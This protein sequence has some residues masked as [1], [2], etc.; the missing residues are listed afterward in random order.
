MSFQKITI[1]VAIVLL[2]VA[3]IFVAVSL[4]RTKYDVQYPP[5]Q[6]QCP[7]YWIYESQN[8]GCKNVKGL[9][10]TTSKSCP[11]EMKFDKYAEFT[12]SDALCNKYKWAKKCDLTWDGIT[13]NREACKTEK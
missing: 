9:G 5:V 1:S 8:E 7:D 12:G 13:N 11:M 6:A 4:Y 2:V 10:N 3:L